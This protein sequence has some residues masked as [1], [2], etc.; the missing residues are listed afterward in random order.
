M[1]ALRDYE[2]AFSLLAA[3]NRAGRAEL[4]IN[5]AWRGVASAP[6]MQ[7]SPALLPEARLRTT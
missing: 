7:P 6:G 5:A 4:L 2:L 1:E 3:D